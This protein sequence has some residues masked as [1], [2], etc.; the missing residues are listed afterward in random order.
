MTASSLRL[1][2]HRR[3][4][5]AGTRSANLRFCKLRHLPSDPRASLITMSEWPT[6]LRLATKFEPMNPAP[7]VT[8]NIDHHLACGKPLGHYIAAIAIH[9]LR[10]R[11]VNGLAQKLPQFKAHAFVALTHLRR[12][13]ELA[14]SGALKK[15]RISAR[16]FWILKR[17]AS[18]R[19]C[20][21]SAAAAKLGIHQPRSSLARELSD[22]LRSL[23]DGAGSLVQ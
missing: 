9:G 5:L 1:S 19:S 20:S 2:S 23:G 14:T 6:S 7:P 21:D 11:C 12:R 17:S 10:N 16:F 3:S 15:D 22:A 13:Q 4:S 8:S 18:T